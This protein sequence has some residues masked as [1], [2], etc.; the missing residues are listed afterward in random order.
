MLKWL[1]LQ[2]LTLR[3][4]KSYSSLRESSTDERGLCSVT[5][6]LGGQP[7]V[8]ETLVAAPRIQRVM[9]RLPDGNMDGTGFPIT[10]YQSL[11]A[12]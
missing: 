1:E 2:M 12:L 7:V 5:A 6:I 4:L 10:G 3:E 9:F 11:R 8:V